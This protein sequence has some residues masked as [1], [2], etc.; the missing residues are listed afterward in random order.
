[1]KWKK[2]RTLALQ[3]I[4]A[5]LRSYVGV[6]LLARYVIIRI[7]IAT[8]KKFYGSSNTAGLIFL[9]YE[10]F[11]GSELEELGN[12]KSFGIFLLP[13]TLLD[14][15][16]SVC[17]NHGEISLT[18]TLRPL[19]LHEDKE[20]FGS[21][22]QNLRSFYLKVL[23]IVFAHFNVKA[24]IGVAP[25]YRQNH[26]CGVV[27]ARLGYPYIILMKEC[28]ITNRKHHERIVNF[29]S[30]MDRDEISHVVVY[31]NA[32]KVA[33]AE[34]R[35]VGKEKISVLGCIRMDR[36]IEKVQR[37][38]SQER[39]RLEKK[40]RV[41]LFSFIHG[42][43]LFGWAPAMPK[44]G[45]PGFFELFDQ[46][47]QTIARLAARRSDV[48]FVIKVKWPGSYPT[49][50]VEECFNLAGFPIGTLPNVLISANLDAQDLILDSD[51]VI[52]F[53][54]TTML[55][56]AIA[57][58]PV[59]VPNFS[60]AIQKAYLEYIQL[61]DTYDAYDVAVSAEHLERL[62]ESRLDDGEISEE[63]RAKR[64]K[65]FSHY[66]SDIAG[67]ATDRYVET[68]T[69]IIKANELDSNL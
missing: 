61:A 57:D 59:I 67:G 3:G 46:V 48:E 18:A 52:S 28:L 60:E 21:N 53:G 58:K 13:K 66:V 26:D 38:K 31:N 2:F 11:P 14:I 36:F 20:V 65:Y 4:K 25:H 39:R 51:V 34:S 23:P 63:V 43:G 62:I 54:S 56:A 68:I 19:D 42:V 17:W 8:P 5:F 12:R 7:R 30:K 16:N 22:R 27:A 55:E 29:Y 9:S 50:E 35:I 64:I 10:R 49:R 33:I 44:K 69:E 45:G 6:Q 32:T 15:L 41:V 37:E 40:K 47:H 1:M 24:V